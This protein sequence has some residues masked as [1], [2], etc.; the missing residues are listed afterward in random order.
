MKCNFGLVLYVLDGLQGH[1]AL[2]FL[3]TICLLY[4]ID[5]L[6]EYVL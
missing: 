3:K 6:F 2:F 5:I 4:Y 1:I